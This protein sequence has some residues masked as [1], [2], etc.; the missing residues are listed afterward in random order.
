MTALPKAVYA[1]IGWF[2]AKTVVLPDDDEAHTQL[3]AS[4]KP[5]S[6]FDS[7][8]ASS[9]ERS[10]WTKIGTFSGLSLLS[11]L[12]GLWFS[13]SVLLSLT[14]LVLSL[15]LHSALVSH[16]VKRILHEQ[17]LV[18][19]T[20]EL[21]EHLD[22]HLQEQKNALQEQLEKLEYETRV[23][24]DN[25]TALTAQV[26]EVESSTQELLHIEQEVDEV[27]HTLQKDADNLTQALQDTQHNTEQLSHSTDAFHQEVVYIGQTHQEFNHLVTDLSDAV[28][29]LTGKT[30]VA[31]VESTFCK[32]LETA[33]QKKNDDIAQHLQYYQELL[34]KQ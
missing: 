33:Q 10:F 29:K 13:A 2:E 20:S 31:E 8:C 22:T 3:V 14:V 5:Q 6:W 7:L 12:I 18:H 9:A 30:E 21:Q 16:H 4:L 19:S 17:S 15:G 34:D 23:F 11:G 1:L 32:E 27:V 24:H 25:N 26:E 28:D